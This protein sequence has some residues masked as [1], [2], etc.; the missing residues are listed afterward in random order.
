M[1]SL[2]D[3]KK[4]ATAVVPAPSSA[5]LPTYLAL[6]A[7]GLALGLSFIIFREIKKM[8]VTMIKLEKEKVPT[9]LTEKI[10]A[11]DAYTK[12][13][14]Q[15]LD[16]SLT[17]MQRMQAQQQQI[18]A[19]YQILASEVAQKKFGSNDAPPPMDQFRMGSGA[20]KVNGNNTEE[21]EIDSD[22]DDEEPKTKKS[23]K[24]TSG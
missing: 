21:V 16:G 12:E 20:A 3:K 14:S 8:R 19:Q 9:D 1:A 23:K 7:A 2:E 11:S 5:N 15:K 4:L 24:K 10:N 22:S 13:I 6:A 17:A 18:A